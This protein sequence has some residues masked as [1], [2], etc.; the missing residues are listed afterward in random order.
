[1]DLSNLSIAALEDLRKQIDADIKQRQHSEKARL[2]TEIQRLAAESGLTLE[3]ILGGKVTGKK[4]IA[5]VYAN[6]E[7]PTQTWSGRG[8]RPAWFIA[9]LGEGKSEDDLKL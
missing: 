5:A 3:E 8:R 7:D 2:R 1:M 4:A 9:A 6:P